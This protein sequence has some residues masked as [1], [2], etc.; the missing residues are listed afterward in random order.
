[1]PPD[2]PFPD[3]LNFTIRDPKDPN[4]NTTLSVPW[5]TKPEELAARVAQKQADFAAGRQ[6]A[7]IP[8]APENVPLAGAALKTVVKK[9]LRFDKVLDVLQRH[10]KNRHVVSALVYDARV[11]RATF[12]DPNR[13]AEVASTVAEWV[14]REA[15]ELSPT[16]CSVEPDAEFDT[17]VCV[18]KSFVSVLRKNPR[19]N[20]GQKYV[21]STLPIHWKPG[22][23]Q[24]ST[25]AAVHWSRLSRRRA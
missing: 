5:G 22:V 16:T 9:L 12:N 4:N 8:D 14:Q 7:P 3:Q 17:M 20:C 10:R 6:P 2:V 1:M 19:L 24:L 18:P 13:L 23:Q 21:A 25:A 11:N 15:P